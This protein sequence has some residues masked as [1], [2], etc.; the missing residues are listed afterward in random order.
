MEEFLTE[1]FSDHNFD[2]CVFEYYPHINI[3]YKTGGTIVNENIET[4]NMPFSLIKTDTITEYIYRERKMIVESS[5]DKEY[6]NVHQIHCYVKPN[7][8]NGLVIISQIE[9]IDPNKFPVLNS[10]YDIN[11]KVVRTYDDKYITI[12]LISENNDMNYIKI[13]FNITQNEEYKKRIK[14]HFT[15]V[16]SWLQQK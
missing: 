6:Q 1:I 16:I 4:L 3:Q 11:K 9:Y 5:G 13:S 10:Y 12:Q 8:A 7:N 14:R 2:D 15:K